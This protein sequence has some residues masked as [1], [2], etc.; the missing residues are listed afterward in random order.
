[1]FPSHLSIRYPFPSHLPLHPPPLPPPPPPRLLPTPLAPPTCHSVTT[2]TTTSSTSSSS[3]SSSSYSFHLSP[4]PSFPIFLSLCSACHTLIHIFLSF[5]LPSIT[6]IFSPSYSCGFVFPLFS[7]LFSYSFLYYVI[8]F[9]LYSF[10][11]FTNMDT[12]CDPIF[13]YNLYILIIL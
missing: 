12:F 1:M 11:C 2:T 6:R 8:K 10:L 9:F 4:I 5:L 7:C 3:S 13:F